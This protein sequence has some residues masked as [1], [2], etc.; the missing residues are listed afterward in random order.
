MRYKFRIR[1]R[2]KYKLGM[3]Y[4]K[5]RF[6]WLAFQNIKEFSIEQPGSRVTSPL[7]RQS[8]RLIYPKDHVHRL[9]QFQ[10]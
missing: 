7:I 9:L 1:N 3:I 2:A 8:L 4:T 5:M 6:V 10:R